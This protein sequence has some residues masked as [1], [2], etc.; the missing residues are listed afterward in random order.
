MNNEEPVAFI[1]E[2]QYKLEHLEH[3]MG[4]KVD[5]FVALR[6]AEPQ[7]EMQIFIDIRR[8]RNIVNSLTDENKKLME[9]NG[10]INEI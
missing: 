8:A 5:G 2:I 3:E 4:Y 10:G 1:K 7:L 6:Y 9:S